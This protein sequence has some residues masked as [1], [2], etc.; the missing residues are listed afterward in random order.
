[1]AYYLRSRAVVNCAPLGNLYGM[2]ET[3]HACKYGWTLVTKDLLDVIPL[4][5]INSHQNILLI[6]LVIRV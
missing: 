4:Q 2:M 5:K 1:M 6:V 3:K